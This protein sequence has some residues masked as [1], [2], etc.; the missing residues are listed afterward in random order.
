MIAMGKTIGLKV[1]AEGVE[2]EQQRDY[3]KRQNCDILQGYLFA[4]P[5]TASD[6]TDYLQQH[7]RM[8]TARY[9]I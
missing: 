1:V 3:L 7:M 2:T 6:A 8:S 5:L 4:K 9:S